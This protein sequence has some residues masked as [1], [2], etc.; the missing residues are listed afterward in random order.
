MRVVR[1]GPEGAVSLP[2]V[3]RILCYKRGKDSRCFH[4]HPERM[5]R[6]EIGHILLTDRCYYSLVET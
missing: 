1:L 2:E 3:S 5:V 4:R 6:E